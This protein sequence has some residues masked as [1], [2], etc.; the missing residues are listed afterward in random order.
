MATSTATEPE[1]QKN[2]C[3]SGSGVIPTELPRQ[4]DGRLVG[5]PAEHDVGHAS[6]LARR[7][8]AFS[9]GWL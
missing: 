6:E 2:T 4:L 1:S 3:C 5:E 9:S 8:R 7:L